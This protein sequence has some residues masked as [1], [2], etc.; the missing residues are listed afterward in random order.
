V[1]ARI[2]ILNA[3]KALYMLIVISKEKQLSFSW[4]K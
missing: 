1:K 4:K 2:H 3:N